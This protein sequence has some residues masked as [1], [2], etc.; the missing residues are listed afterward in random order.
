MMCFPVFCLLLCKPGC[1]RESL[2]AAQGSVYL[3]HGW[4]VPPHRNASKG[5]VKMSL[6]FSVF[7]SHFG[8]LNRNVLDKVGNDSVSCSASGE[9]CR[10]KTL[11][12]IVETTLSLV[13]G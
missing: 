1:C 5:A 11:T 4:R 13:G 2:H 9:S 7:P 6:I 8:F 3:G 12:T 10:G